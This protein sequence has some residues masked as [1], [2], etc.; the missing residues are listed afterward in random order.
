MHPSTLLIAPLAPQEFDLAWPIFHAV[1]S[2]GDT[3]AFDPATTLE[4]A[5]RLWT[6]P[7]ARAFLATSG[8]VTVGTYMLRPAQ[9]GLGNHVANAGYMVAP[10]ARR[11]GVARQLCEHSLEVARQMGFAAM[12][13]NF[14][15]AT[16]QGAIRLW[17]RCG[18]E[19]V[20]RA[21][22]TF[23]HGTEGLVD[24]LVMHRFL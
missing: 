10:S 18:F 19:I 14:V 20:G 5:R 12:Q 22:R 8:G 21:P 24:T 11:Q 9:P 15:V 6:A 23:R 13:F 2:A 3:Y 16:N 17:E 1:V 7:P 4:E